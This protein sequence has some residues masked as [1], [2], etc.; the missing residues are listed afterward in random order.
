M[1]V[2]VSFLFFELDSEIRFLGYLGRDLFSV[3]VCELS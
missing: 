2:C 1:G 3:E